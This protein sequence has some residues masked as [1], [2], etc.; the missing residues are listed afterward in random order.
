VNLTMIGCDF[1]SAPVELREKL[2]F[3]DAKLDRALDELVSRYDCEAVI[4]S[5]CNRVELYIARADLAPAL[6]VELIAEFLSDIHSVPAPAIMPALLSLHA[7]DTVNHLFRVAGG[8]DSMI[9]GEGQIAGQVKRAYERSVQK[10]AS[11]AL[12]HA[13]FQHA[14]V[15][16]KRIRTETG[17]SR[18]R[19]S[20]SSVAVDYVREVF[21]RFDDKTVLVIGAG[22]M[23]E[24]TLR[25]LRG[26]NPLR[27]LVTNR[28]PQKAID[29]AGQC[30][31]VAVPWEELDRALVQADIILSTT[32]APEPIVTAARWNGVMNQRGGSTVVILDIAVPRDFEPSIHDG[33][34]TYLFNIDDLKS[35]QERTLS[36]RR[37]HMQPAEEIVS[38]EVD[39]FLAEWARRKRGP[40][41][42]RLTQDVDRKRREIVEQLMTRLNGR[43][44][45]E[46]KQFIEKA[47]HLFQN[48]I[49]HGP[50]SALD[51]SA[52]E[53]SLLEA[54]RKLFR[55]GES[56]KKN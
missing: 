54:V 49:L 14:F 1:R 47:F 42:A 26:L 48:R 52:H 13:L 53:G 37:R 21:N 18:G 8:L 5:T 32:G 4:L 55:L 31:G 7:T 9:V 25:H 51:E 23:G 36:E 6:D 30:R 19:A 35:I 46:D 28:S 10:S 16:A 41:I 39:R 24:L 27:I 12:L 2:A 56:E 22:K 29:I 15:A 44:T 3:D 17:I 45:D 40:V 11:G 50:I 33:D 34:R 20:V 43:L 38:Q